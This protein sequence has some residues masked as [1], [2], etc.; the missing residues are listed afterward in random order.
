MIN[1]GV[2]ILT[3]CGSDIG[4]GHYS[5]CFSIYQELLSR[6]IKAKFILFQAGS[7]TL[8]IDDSIE[9]IE[10]HNNLESLSRFTDEYNVLVDS[11]KLD[12]SSFNYIRKLFQHVSVIDDYN[13]LNYPVDIL[14][15][16]NVYFEQVNYSNQKTALCYG[17][18]DFVI[19]RKPFRDA[20]IQTDRGSRLKSA[21]ITLGGSDERNLLTKLCRIFNVQSNLRITVICPDSQTSVQL[22]KD[23]PTIACC[24]GLSAIEMLQ[25][26]SEND[27]VVSG[28]GQTL[29]ELAS[30]GKPTI[31]LCLGDDQKLNQ[32]FYFQNSW[33][34]QLIP[35]DDASLK[36]KL[37]ANFAQFKDQSLRIKM[38]EIGPALINKDGVESVVDLI[39]QTKKLVFRQPTIG[40]CGLYF[41]WVNDPEVRKSAINTNLIDWPNHRVWFSNKI[42]DSQSLMMLFF[43]G[44]TPVGQIRVDWKNEAG[45]IDYSIDQAFRGQRLG[46]LMISALKELLDRIP[47]RRVVYGKVKVGNHPSIKTFGKAGF[48]DIGQERI[49]GE[50]FSIYKY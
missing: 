31:G 6:G 4:Y 14:I 32:A 13:R 11:Y 38:S 42:K 37:E 15:N 24:F 43:I 36:E 5:R 28:C 27:I 2:L 7:G 8:A 30:I 3:E 25:A 44:S 50:D 12:L 10:W 49:N 23:Y 47:A 46:V 18:K 35:W 33:L 19:L 48:S 21:L 40:D 22:S 16:P 26:F 1:K 41:S 29:H 17:G 20:N 39:S 34:L 45:H 9:I